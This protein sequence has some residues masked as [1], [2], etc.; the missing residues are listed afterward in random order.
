MPRLNVRAAIIVMLSIA[1]AL[2]FVIPY[3]VPL[4]H[5]WTTAPV[6]ATSDVVFLYWVMFV[7]GGVILLIVEGG[8]IAAAILFRERPGH[9][10]KVFHGHPMLEFAWTIIPAIIV[11][12]LSIGSIRSL[13][14]LND[15]AEAG[16]TI[17]VTG[18]QWF[19]QFRYPDDDLTVR[20]EVRI[21]TNT[22]VRFR[23]TSADVIH[24]FWVPALSGKLDAVP[25]R[26]AEIWMT[27]P[28]PGKFAGQCAEFCGLKHADMLLTVVA[29]PPDQ[30]KAWIAKTKE[31]LAR[32]PTPEE[33]RQV[34]QQV[35]I[36]CHSLEKGKASP[37]AAA[38]N[39]SEYAAQGPFAAQLRSLKEKDPE[40]L[41]KWVTNAPAIK[42]GTAMPP[43]Q[44]V[45]QPKQIE[46]VVAY[47][48]TLK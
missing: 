26:Q 9:Q 25:G 21:P 35:C 42:P 32:A 19:W 20:D 29:E 11:V 39:L 8:I 27:A 4:G 1:V 18:R 47:L 34:A 17:E 7:I 24:S 3:V 38:P 10:A 37:L 46:A 41:K 2:V 23:I 28:E 48:L 31:E 40:W 43:W 33:G 14:V 5:T 6:P 16:T 15:T 45:L 30:V 22:K 13:Q 44:G 36:A 12:G